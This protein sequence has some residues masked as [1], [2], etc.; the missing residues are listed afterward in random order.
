MN[1]MKKLLAAFIVIFIVLFGCITQQQQAPNETIKNVSKNQSI[2]ITSQTNYT[3]A[4]NVPTAEERESKMRNEVL[5][6]ANYTYSPDKPI[7][8]YFIYV[9][10]GGVQADSI[11]IKK[12]DADIL[13]DT[14]PASASTRVVQF[15]KERGV[16]D[17]ELLILTHAD[18][19]H[20]G[21]TNAIMG[22]FTI[23]K[24]I[25]SG[26]TY[27]DNDFKQLLDSIDKRLIPVKSVLRGDVESINGINLTVLNPI[28]TS[29]ASVDE[30]AIALKVSDRNFCVL[31]TS[32]VFGRGLDDMTKNTDV[33][34]DIVQIPR[35]GADHIGVWL[36]NLLK[37]SK[38][39]VAIISGSYKEEIKGI[40]FRKQLFER[41]EQDGIA[42]YENYVNGSIR[43]MSDGSAYDIDFVR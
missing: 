30:D 9:G 13:I 14:G 3:I 24:V 6:A 12:G 16:D 1:F 43:I 38:A 20:Y 41:L 37:K 8:V 15:L 36:I 22:N 34:C 21:G 26:R 40:D 25:W 35:S 19:E 42:H 39:K 4:G 17:L 5:N 27:N 28:E 32:D 18:K 29:F 23:G 31:L 7:F 33:E 10:D 2:T 11:L